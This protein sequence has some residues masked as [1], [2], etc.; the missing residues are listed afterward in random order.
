MAPAHLTRS[1]HGGRGGNSEFR[2]QNAEFG[3][4]GR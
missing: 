1:D 3:P 4:K 2:I